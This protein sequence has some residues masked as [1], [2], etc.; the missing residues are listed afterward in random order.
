MEEGKEIPEGDLIE[1]DSPEWEELNRQAEAE[2]AEFKR[3]VLENPFEALKRAT[4]E[5]VW[6]GI[7]IVDQ[8]FQGSPGNYYSQQQRRNQ[9]LVQQIIQYKTSEDVP[10]DQESWSTSMALFLR[11]RL[12]MNRLVPQEFRPSKKERLKARIEDYAHF[13]K[14]TLVP[15]SKGTIKDASS[16]PQTLEKK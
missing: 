7:Q 2:K 10:E 5:E 12:V 13:L 6:E 4:F 1:E 9:E 15:T 3:I 8:Q 16:E 14:S 11:D